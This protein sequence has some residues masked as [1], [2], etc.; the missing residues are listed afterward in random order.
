MRVDPDQELLQR[1]ITSHDNAAFEAILRRRVPMVFDVCRSALG[2]DAD[3]EDAFQATFL[4]LARKATSIREAGTLASW[5]HGVAHRTAIKARS[6]AAPQGT[7][8]GSH[9]YDNL[10]KRPH[11]G[12]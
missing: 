8:R 6:A 3:A 11:W 1:F 5:L 12:L 4:L 7:R 9:A 2:N 10:A